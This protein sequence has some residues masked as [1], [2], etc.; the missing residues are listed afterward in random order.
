MTLDLIGPQPE[1]LGWLWFFFCNTC[2][3][4]LL[5]VLMFLSLTRMLLILKVSLSPHPTIFSFYAKPSWGKKPHDQCY[6]SWAWQAKSFIPD[7]LNKNYNLKRLSQARSFNHTKL[8]AEP[9]QKLKSHK[10]WIQAKPSQHQGFG[11]SR[12]PCSEDSTLSLSHYLFS[13]SLVLATMH[14]CCCWEMGFKK[15]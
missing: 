8:G 15:V 7:Y 4:A 6:L 3:L 11:S 13:F 12:S 1:G 2:N 5:G 14:F 10:S 9:H